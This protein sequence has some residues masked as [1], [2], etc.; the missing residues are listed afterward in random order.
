[1]LKTICPECK[2]DMT[3]ATVPA[4]VIL[5]GRRVLGPWEC[6]KCSWVGQLRE[7]VFDA[8]TPYTQMPV[9]VGDVRAK[10]FLKSLSREQLTALKE[11][12]ESKT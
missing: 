12:L 7:L 3:Y 5:N 6:T 8:S 4:L 1:M 11:Q 2:T 10:N 9:T